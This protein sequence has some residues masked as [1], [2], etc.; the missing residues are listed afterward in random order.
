MPKALRDELGL[1]AGAELEL[2]VVDGR[3]EAQR[4][5]LSAELVERGGVLVAVPSESL[6][7][8]TDEDVRDALERARR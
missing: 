2:R 7:T 8:L 3:L 6:P 5:A 1:S 4:P